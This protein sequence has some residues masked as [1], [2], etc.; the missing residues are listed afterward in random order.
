MTSLNPDPNPAP[1]P[2]PVALRQRRAATWPGRRAARPTGAYD[3]DPPVRGDPDTPG[4]AGLEVHF[5]GEDGRTATFSFATLP[6]SGLHADLAAAFARLTGPA[7]GLRTLTSAKGAWEMLGRLVRFLDGLARPPRDVTRLTA[8]HLRR[9]ELRRRQT[10]N[11]RS[12]AHDLGNVRRLLCSI[13][14]QSRLRPDVMDWLGQR[15]PC[16]RR[17]GVPG[18]SEQEFRR[19][20]TAARSDVAAIRDRIHATER[21]LARV[22]THPETLT[23][24]DRAAAAWLQP[25]ARTGQVP[26]VRV[27]GGVVFDNVE[28]LTLA[29]QL[30]PVDADLAP[31]L[32]L[33]VG[34]TG[35]NSETLKELPASHE[36]LEARAVTLELVKRRRGPNN[37]HE[38][39][40]WEVGAPSRQL[41]TPGGYYLLVHEL[42]RR[43]RAF[44]GSASVW[45]IW[46]VQSG[47]ISPFAKNLNRRLYLGAWAQKHDLRSDDGQPLKLT[48]NRL[49]TTV[50]VRTTKAAGGHL[51]TSARTNTM[52][53]QFAHYLR[54]DPTVVEWAAEEVSA[55]VVD[56]EQHARQAHLR[57]LT[58]P[59][60]QHAKD[61]AATAAQ[62]GVEPET[63]RQALAGELDTLVAACL[64]IDDSP[65]NEGRCQASFLTCLRCRNALATHRHLPGMLALLEQLDFERQTTDAELWW[66]RH[67][68][69][70]LTITEGVLPKFT[71][72]EIERAKAAA[73]PTVSL[74]ELLHGPREQL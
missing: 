17:S 56:A 59:E 69:T 66:A 70:W 63:A 20:M 55:A 54:G 18:Y 42:A 51:P 61:L 60:E 15:C 39:V 9:F 12:V 24:A 7:G 36:L 40:H 45:S 16:K 52:D 44:S 30:Y 48:L 50:E 35:R 22:D 58:G 28:M 2:D 46:N 68:P 5:A 33:G 29:K 4:A 57:V 38:Q 34:L 74:L 11:P 41:H 67:G 65:F 37:I 72:A 27:P 21:L 3:L 25:I 32:V 6:L 73:T 19:I 47:H 1:S 62:L 31:L 53:V 71:P 23:A 10:C 64:N 49:R 13:T 43:G 8:R 14:P 26:I